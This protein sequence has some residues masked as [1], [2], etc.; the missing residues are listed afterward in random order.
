MRNM[1]KGMG[2]EETA[3]YMAKSVAEAPKHIGA[4]RILDRFQNELNQ[5]DNIREWVIGTTQYGKI[6]A[7]LRWLSPEPGG[8]RTLLGKPVV[9]EGESFIGYRSQDGGRRIAL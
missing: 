1:F 2:W 7:Y 8:F 3:D 5:N 4:A 9:V 6:L